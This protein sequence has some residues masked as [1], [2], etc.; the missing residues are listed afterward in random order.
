ME[1]RFIDMVNCNHVIRGV[2]VEGLAILLG[3][4]QFC[5][6][7]SPAIQVFPVL[8]VSALLSVG[9]CSTV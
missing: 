4:C 6:F 2:C 5:G 8:N 1:A 3:M 9:L 7:E